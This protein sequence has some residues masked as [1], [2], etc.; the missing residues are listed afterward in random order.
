MPSYD[1]NNLYFHWDMESYNEVCEIEN[2]MTNN[3]SG[4]V[5]MKE[6]GVND[7]KLFRLNDED[8]HYYYQTIYYH[9]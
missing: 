6:Y 7:L 3:K 4:T 9:F 8:Q 5:L 2:V 1:R